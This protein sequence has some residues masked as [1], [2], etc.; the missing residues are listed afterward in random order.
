MENHLAAIQSSRRIQHS[1]ASVRTMWQYR[2]DAIQCL[3]SIRVSTSRHSYGKMAAT[4]RAMC[5]P[6]RTM[7]SIKQVLHSKSRCPDVS[8]L[9]PD[10]RASDMEIV[11]IRSTVQTTIPLVRTHEALVWKLLAAEV[12]LFGRQ[13]TIIRTRLKLGKNF[14]RSFGKPIV[15]LSVRKPYD[16]RPD[17]A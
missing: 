10:T 11:C 14:S 9:G 5:D 7:S 17:G 6:V 4:V 15:Q 16:Y 1:S 3:A 2:P 13:G 12:R 8:P